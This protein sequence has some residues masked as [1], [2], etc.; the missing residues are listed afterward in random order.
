MTEK[1]NENNVVI[2]NLKS[3]FFKNLKHNNFLYRTGLIAICASLLTIICMFFSYK[4]ALKGTLFLIPLSLIINFCYIYMATIKRKESFITM[5]G[6]LS[7]LFNPISVFYIHLID[8]HNIIL[9]LLVIFILI[10]WFIAAV[11]YKHND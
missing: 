2:N 1:S 8:T 11:N 10:H 5:T 4:I 3:L 6:I 9:L 7:I